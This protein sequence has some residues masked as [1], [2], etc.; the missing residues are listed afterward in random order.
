MSDTL[1]IAHLSDVHLGPIAGFTPRYWNLKRA[2]GFVN[3]HRTRRHVHRATWSTGSSPT[4]RRAGARPRRRDRRPRQHRPAGGR[5]CTRC[6]GSKSLGAP[7][8]TSRWC[9]ATTTSTPSSAPIPASS[10]GRAYMAPTIGDARPPAPRAG[11][12]YVRRVWAGR[13][14]RPQLGGPTPPLHRRRPARRARSSHAAARLLD[15]LA[16]EPLWRLVLIHHPPLPGQARPPARIGGCGRSCR[17]CWRRSAPNWS[18]TATT[19][20]RTCV[21]LRARACGAVHVIGVASASAGI[22]TAASRWRRYNL[23]RLNARPRASACRADRA[24]LGD[25]TDGAMVEIE[26]PLAELSL[27]CAVLH[28]EN[29]AAWHCRPVP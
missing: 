9:P 20:C 14:D 4:S 25:P 22:G 8:A 11:F 2:L 5:S 13:A 24:R 10:A 27:Q 6:A 16:A 28:P 15:R 17:P 29:S 1:T 19:I 12:P 3:W 26:R 7:A 18:C 21:S 23:L